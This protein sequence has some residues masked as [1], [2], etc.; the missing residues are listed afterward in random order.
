MAISGLVV[1]VALLILNKAGVSNADVETIVNSL[2]TRLALVLSSVLL[3]LVLVAGVMIER[4]LSR[5]INNEEIDQAKVHAQTLLASLRTFMLNGQGTLARDW[6][7]S[8]HGAPGIVDVEVLRR[9]GG[10]AFTDLTTVGKVN[11][12]LGD[13]V[14]EREPSPAHHM[15][16]LITG[17]FEQALNGEV[18]LDLRFPEEITVF[19]PI[20]VETECLACHGY[21]AG[22]MRGVLR[23]S[24]SREQGAIRIAAMRHNLWAIA[25][26]LVLIIAVT[27]LLVLRIYVLSPVNR[28]KDAI[29]RVGAGERH[30]E[31]PLQWRD[32]LGQVAAVFNDM[33]EDLV[34]NET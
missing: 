11:N 1:S 25:A 19:Q 12:F 34:A 3:G 5:A 28:L 24:L 17:P 27:M 29:I 26:L 8:M 18:A 20:E 7:N 15:P 33:Q 16:I 4:Q 21:D 13:P 2:G 32:E 23:L 30:V 22:S 10:E 14:F 6:L 9:D 31:L